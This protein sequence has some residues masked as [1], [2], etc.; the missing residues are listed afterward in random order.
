MIT[1]LLLLAHNTAIIVIQFLIRCIIY[2]LYMLVS[3]DARHDRLSSSLNDNI[4]T[5]Y[6][7]VIGV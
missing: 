6:C 5:F 7:S 3:N 2:K 1:R 4:T